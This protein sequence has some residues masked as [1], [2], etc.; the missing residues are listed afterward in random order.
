[1]FDGPWVPC[2]SLARRLCLLIPIAVAEDCARCRP[3]I[4]RLV[5]A[6]SAA[7]LWSGFDQSVHGQVVTFSP[8]VRVIYLVPSDREIRRDYVR[9]LDSAIG[10]VQVWLRNELGDDLS[11]STIKKPV[12]VIQTSHTAAWYRENSVG[13]F[14]IWFFA[15]VLADGF[16]LTGGQ[17]DDPSNIWVFYIDSDP[18]CG[19]L[20]GA[21][22]GVAVLPA[23]D[24]RGLAG[25]DNIPPCPG[26][27]PDT[28]GVCR[29]VGGLGHELG[30]ALGL[31]HPSACEAGDPTCPSNTLMWLG[32]ITYPDTFLLESDK[33]ILEN[34]P[35]I[36]PVHI[37]HSLPACTKLK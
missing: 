32:Y 16:D 22:A 24:L 27:P 5:L 18:A 13:D 9:H 37:R 19:Q 6:L 20:V 28:A 21:A 3:S 23:N 26:Q 8:V 14:A 10:H 29:W 4:L 35:F 30:H 36:S 7:S 12:Q 31:P 34:S 1:M 2:L 15:N 33:T 17:F 11:F 25:E